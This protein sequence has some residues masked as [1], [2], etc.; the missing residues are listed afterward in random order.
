MDFGWLEKKWAWIDFGWKADCKRL[1]PQRDPKRAKRAHNIDAEVSY[2]FVLYR[3]FA[4]SALM[5]HIYTR[6]CREVAVSA[7]RAPRTIRF[8]LHFL[9]DFV[10]HQILGENFL[11][12]EECQIE[13]ELAPKL[14]P[15]FKGILGD[16]V[17]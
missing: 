5:P 10:T 13:C 7:Q 12:S 17:M 6:L 3:I 2:A 15:K 8:L 1:E 14:E 9:I 4:S 16:A 11:L